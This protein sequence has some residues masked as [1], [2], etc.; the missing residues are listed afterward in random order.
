MKN[1]VMTFAI[2][3]LVSFLVGCQDPNAHKPS[4]SANDALVPTV[5]WMDDIAYP[6]S[7]EEFAN[8]FALEPQCNGLS[9]YHWNGSSNDDKLRIL[10]S[11]HW[12]VGYNGSDG[13]GGEGRQLFGFSIAPKGFHGGSEA[14]GLVKSPEEAAKKA[15]FVAKRRGGEVP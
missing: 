3:T 15:C 1:T 13:P 6:K 2:L 4:N 11:P 7:G 14:G 9:F 5:L 12:E 8:A 10:K